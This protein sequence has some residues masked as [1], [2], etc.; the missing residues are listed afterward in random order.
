MSK[1]PDLTALMSGQALLVEEALCVNVRSRTES[2][3]A[4]ADSCSV[5]AL[6]LTIDSV[7]VDSDRCTG[8]GACLPACPAGVLSLSGFSPRRFVEMLGR[9][10]AV[11][12]HCSA[13]RDGGGGVVIPC[14][15]VLDARLIAAACANGTREFLLHGLDR[16][17]ACD[18]GDAVPAMEAAQQQLD[19]WFGEEA[20]PLLIAA[21]GDA[22]DAG[23]RR[24][25]NQPQMSRRNFLRFAGV[26]ALSSATEWLVPEDEEEEDPLA[27]I[28]PVELGQQQ[29]VVYQ[30]LL[31]EHVA[32]L[33]WATRE[34][35]WRGR[36]LSESCSACLS[37]G[38]R[39]P[40][41]ALQAEEQKAGQGISFEPALCTDCGLCTHVCPMEAVEPHRL[42][43]PAQVLAPRSILVYRQTMDCGHCGHTFLPESPQ[44]LLCAVCRN[45]Q[46]LDDEWLAMLEE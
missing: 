7:D 44:Q 26:Q 2:C 39:C 42:T 6:A 14:H 45:E 12:L 29:A 38:Q 19:D 16:C 36:T 10:E 8:C 15:K 17:Q 35:P 37:C 33:P 31:A 24:H 30:S 34:L 1:R 43:E 27:G 46:E 32:D 11:H 9:A 4:C 5:D 22:G 40:S 23:E 21:E 25:E 20:T 28:Y 3:Q 13:S 41:G 18:K